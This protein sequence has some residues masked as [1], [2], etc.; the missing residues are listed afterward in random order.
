[1]SVRL[2]WNGRPIG[3]T[4]LEPHEMVTLRISLPYIAWRDG[5]LVQPTPQLRREGWKGRR[6]C[7]TVL[8]WRGWAT[9]VKIGAW[10]TREEAVSLRLIAPR[11]SRLGE[12]ISLPRAEG[13]GLRAHDVERRPIVRRS[14]ISS[15]PGR[16][17]RA[18][19]AEDEGRRRRGRRRRRRGATTDQDAFSSDFDPTLWGLPV[20]ALDQTDR[21]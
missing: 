13:A 14:R 2:D 7:A 4:R 11:R 18:W 21:L 1:M 20:D 5:A 10:Y 17:R 3:D 8:P 16:N 9:A 19:P 12:P 15:R 6:I